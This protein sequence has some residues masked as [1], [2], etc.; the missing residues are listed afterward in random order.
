MDNV[1]NTLTHYGYPLPSARG[2]ITDANKRGITH[3]LTTLRK[4]IRLNSRIF[5][6]DRIDLRIS[7]LS[8]NSWI[9]LS[10]FAQRE[11]LNLS[12]RVSNALSPSILAHIHNSHLHDLCL[13]FYDGN[14]TTLKEWL[15]LSVNHD[16]NV[17]MIVPAT[18]Y[19]PQQIDTLL[20]NSHGIKAVTLSATDTFC[21]SSPL[22][23]ALESAAVIKGMN[24]LTRQ[25]SNKGIDACL[26][27]IPFCQVE[28]DNL[29]R[30]FDRA[31][32]YLDHSGYKEDSYVFAERMYS[33]TTYRLNVAL[34]NLVSR[35]IHVH[36]SL[37]NALF[38]WIE[39]HRRSYYRIW[40]YHKLTRH[41]PFLKPRPRPVPDQETAHSQALEAYRLKQQ[42][43][44]GP[45]CS[46]CKYRLICDK[47]SSQFRRRFPGLKPLAFPGE[48][49]PALRT[50]HDP[51]KRY[52][53]N[54]DL[55]RLT[56]PERQKQLAEE[57]QKTLLRTPPDR[58]IVSDSYEIENRYT[59]HMPGAVRW[60]SFNKGEL[61]ST[62]LTRVE[63]PFILSFSVGGG[64][65]THAG[66]AFGR[67]IKLYI[68]LID[69]SHRLT[70]S[71]DKDGYF[72]L[73]RDDEIVKAAT[74]SMV[75]YVPSRLK[76]ILEPRLTL[77]NIDG[78]IV[79]Q[80]ISLWES[81]TPLLAASK[82]A[83]YS[84]IIVNT[85]YARRLQATLLALAHQ[86]G[87]EKDLFEVILA[88]VPGIDPTDDLLDSL[89]FSYPDL[90]IVP[91]PVPKDLAHSKGLMINEA[92]KIAS[93][94]WI[95]LT[96]ADIVM[97]PDLFEQ[98]EAIEDTPYLIAPEGRKMLPPDVTAKILLNELK[99][100]E[101][102]DEILEGPGDLRKEEALAIPIGFFQCF[103][104]WLLETIPY[105]ELTHFEASDWYFGKNV[106]LKYGPEYRMKGVYLL[107][108]DHGGSQW[109][110][111]QRQR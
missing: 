8:T 75:D 26:Y 66:F 100:W 102:F 70:L 6:T 105:H 32:Y 103:P 97:P 21:P 30:A 63:A 92:V 46:A 87:I 12:L 81:S 23:N 89:H 71:V 5:K 93:G 62:V 28:A 17:R 88:Y 36:S 77:L 79:T 25:L 58:E 95:M 44:D 14:Y 1:P 96:D 91:F 69:V 49:V 50:A 19:L 31:Q 4:W 51:S 37:D 47:F 59:H 33:Y 9:E 53:D 60:H 3:D 27:G 109:Y 76:G 85:R 29:D 41:L 57:T 43:K 20:E 2:L 78:M 86:K 45:V 64:A 15:D 11:E 22:K 94:D 67:H 98:L 61:F 83:K 82:K 108:L 68:P 72:V 24:E 65:A 7:S 34:D 73:L 55:Q 101:C 56:I 10:D 48:S 107:H 35:D 106:V 104:K 90:R 16:I 54:L 42:K 74:F 13:E 99:P 39:G 80:T 40:A 110:G 18:K 38:P 84:I 111:T 52:Y